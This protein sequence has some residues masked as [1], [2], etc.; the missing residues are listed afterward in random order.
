[1]ATIRRYMTDDEL[2]HEFKKLYG[3]RPAFMELQQF[4]STYVPL[5][6]YLFDDTEKENLKKVRPKYSKEYEYP[7]ARRK[8]EAD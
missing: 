6:R 5:S 4:R 8:R 7:S 2:A 1:M 3:K